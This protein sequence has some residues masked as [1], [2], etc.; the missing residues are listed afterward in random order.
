M[1]AIIGVVVVL[2]AVVGGYV[3]EGGPIL[4][5][6]QPVELLIIG[7]A[8][9]GAIL[10]ATPLKIL[11]ILV[12]RTLGVLG[13][14]HTKESYLELLQVMHDIFLKAKRDGYTAID[15]DVALPGKSA[16]FTKYPG[17]LANHHAV[18]FLCDSL[19]LLVDGAVNAEDLEAMMDTELETHHEEGTKPAS[20]LA[21]VGDSLPGLGI[22]AAVLGIV[23]TMQHIDGPPE[24]IGHKVAVALVGTFLGILASY[25]IVQPLAQNIEHTADAETKYLACIKAALVAFARGAAPIVAV[26]FARRVIFSYDRPTNLEMENA[27]K[28][29]PAGASAAA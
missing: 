29:L 14:G 5:L 22:V 7:G 18:S 21:K 24:E 16:I 3:L 12:R 28:R 25:G 11:T 19:R 23:I 4:V 10:I 20:I 1:F 9:V 6:F 2:G 27:C 17:F 8:C 13:T 15:A 26:E